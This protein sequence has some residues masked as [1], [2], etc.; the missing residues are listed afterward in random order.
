MPGV[1]RVTWSRHKK[2]SLG[3][4]GG[5]RRWKTKGGEP[6]VDVHGTIKGLK[7]RVQAEDGR[8]PVVHSSDARRRSQKWEFVGQKWP[9]RPCK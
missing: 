5:P 7:I 2:A 4:F 8:T 6:H 1:A 3:F 9:P